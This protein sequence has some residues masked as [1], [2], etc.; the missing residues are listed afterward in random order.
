MLCTHQIKHKA[1]NFPERLFLFLQQMWYLKRMEDYL[2]GLV[3]FISRLVD[4]RLTFKHSGASTS[5]ADVII[6]KIFRNYYYIF[7]NP[8]SRTK[9]KDIFNLLIF[10]LIEKMEESRMI[11][12]KC[13]K[14]NVGR[15]IFIF[16][17][18]F[19]ALY[20]F[21]ICHNFISHRL[22]K[23]RWEYHENPFMFWSSWWYYTH[24]KE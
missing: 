7:K 15:E 10:L 12:N 17:I 19:L 3:V 24:G 11:L 1:S 9:S 22:V 8:H 20:A 2:K 4:F 13:Q 18:Y 16:I 6:S 21:C 5:T 14:I 23:E